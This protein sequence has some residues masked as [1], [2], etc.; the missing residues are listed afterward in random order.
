MKPL[1]AS[2]PPVS[3]YL[4]DIRLS[5]DNLVITLIQ[6]LIDARR[7]NSFI[8]P[9]LLI[10]ATPSHIYFHIFISSVLRHWLIAEGYVSQAE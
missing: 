5:P 7:W 9:K 10:V 3:L 2:R 4:T 8:R 6:A 1:L